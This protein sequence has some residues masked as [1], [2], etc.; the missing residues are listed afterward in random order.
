MLQILEVDNMIVILIWILISIVT[1]S[2][3]LQV[4]VKNIIFLYSKF[5]SKKNKTE[6]DDEEDSS[7]L[8][9]QLDDQKKLQKIKEKITELYESATKLPIEDIRNKIYKGLIVA[10]EIWEDLEKNPQ[11]LKYTNKFANYYLTVYKKIIDR[12]NEFLERKTALER[13]E[14]IKKKMNETFDIM[15]VAFKKMLTRLLE[16]DFLDI[17]TDMEVLKKT[18]DLD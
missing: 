7:K 2:F 9:K 4:N 15:H 12:Y 13:Q 18:T 6:I 17:E 16:D 8:N 11:D 5:S 10:V 3:L 1:I 14:E